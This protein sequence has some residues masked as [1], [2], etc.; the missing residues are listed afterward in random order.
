MLKTFLI[1]LFLFVT[2]FS[3]IAYA[4]PAIF[5]PV[6]KAGSYINGGINQFSINVTDSNLNTTNVSLFIRAQS[7]VSPDIWDRHFLTC[8]NYTLSDWFCAKN[9]S[10][11]IAGDDT[12][13]IFFF[14]A[15]DNN[16]NQSSNGTASSS[17]SLTIDVNPPK[18]QSINIQNFSYVG[19][20]QKVEMNVIDT[21]SGINRS[22][23]FFR[24]GNS[25]FNSSWEN[26]SYDNNLFKYNWTISSLVTNGS[27]YLYFNATDNV[28]NTNV[29]KLADVFVDN[30]LPTITI[31]S[32][33][34]SKTLF[35]N[36]S[37]AVNVKDS[38]SGLT[39]S[40]LYKIGSITDILSCGGTK[41]EINCTVS[42]DST[43]LPD[44][45]YSLV[46]S[47]SDVAGNQNNASVQVQVN[48]TKVSISIAYPSNGA[49]V[50]GVAQINVTINNIATGI[51]KLQLRW[52]NSTG[53]GNWQDMTCG[54]DYKCYYNWDTVSFSETTYT[55]RFNVTG[56]LDYLVGKTTT[57]S[58]DNTKPLITIQKPTETKVN[59]T[60]TASVIILDGSG[61]NESS[62]RFNISTSSDTMTCTSFEG[63][64]RLSCGRT[65]DTT[66]ISDGTY[67]M[68]FLASDLA[69]AGNQN[70][71]SMQTVVAN[72]AYSANLTGSQE[73]STTT[74]V[75]TMPLNLTR[76]QESETKSEGIAANLVTNVATFV[77]S[78]FPTVGVTLFLILATFAYVFYIR[79]KPWKTS[80]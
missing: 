47:T 30:E 21:S 34:P 31:T 7:Q 39:N 22:R 26:T 10:L 61:V 33:T 55:F 76:K 35:D 37:F 60:I 46:F 52:E 3:V 1:S 78:N 15:S 11:L 64:K 72:A 38:Y 66:K 20:N 74:T 41:N 8:Q 50:R 70:I 67:T 69:A 27:Y 19:I 5:N 18:V 45:S 65:F 56:T 80:Y 42:F 13:E 63:G 77:K 75:T 16:G 43:K 58:V 73:T 51:N 54:V 9:I 28:G 4:N 23:V 44:G 59:G 24:F 29:S 57:I 62:V 25:S 32:P 6:P 14:T 12:V 40:T 36:A 49:Y 48:N 2:I 53:V 17:L 79:K 68:Y 71:E